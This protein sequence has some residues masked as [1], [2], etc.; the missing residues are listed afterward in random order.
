MAKGKI[1]PKNLKGTDFKEVEM[2]IKLRRFYRDFL[3]AYGACFGV[4][5]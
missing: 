4:K 3:T 1:T 5:F 2:S